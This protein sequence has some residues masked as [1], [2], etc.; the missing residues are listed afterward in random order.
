VQIG[1]E[2]TGEMEP[3]GMPRHEW[4]DDF[5]HL[6]V[7]EERQLELN[8][9]ELIQENPQVAQAYE[10]HKWKHR[11]A[12]LQKEENMQPPPMMGGPNEQPSNVGGG[13]NAPVQ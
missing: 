2:P 1:E 12:I 9:L 8:Y 7:H 10:L 3:D 4:D 6:K 11:E 5:L 13:A